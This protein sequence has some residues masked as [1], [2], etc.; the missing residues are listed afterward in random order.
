MITVQSNGAAISEEKLERL[1]EPHFT[2]K[3][4]SGLALTYTQNIILNHGGT[5][6][7]ESEQGKGTIFTV[8][9]DFA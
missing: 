7:V 6:Y 3:Q 5:I 9:L 4:G 8:I 2:N 1:F